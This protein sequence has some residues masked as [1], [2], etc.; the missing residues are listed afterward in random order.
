MSKIHIL[1]SKVPEETQKGSEIFDDSQGRV[2]LKLKIN[3]YYK[4]LTRL[5][6][7]P[8]CRWEKKQ[9]GGAGRRLPD[10]KNT[11]I[12]TDFWNSHFCLQLGWHVNHKHCTP[13]LFK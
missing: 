1:G 4:S 8:P 11:K 13:D 3:C 12:N 6:L 5:T 10:L 7:T 2:R 9:K